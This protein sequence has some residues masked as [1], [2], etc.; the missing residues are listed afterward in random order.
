MLSPADQEESA[1]EQRAIVLALDGESEKTRAPGCRC[2]CRQA[3]AAA[4]GRLP[5]PLV[6]LPAGCCR[7]LLLPWLPLPHTPAW[8]ALLLDMHS[9]APSRLALLLAIVQLAAQ[10]Q[11]K[12]PAPQP[13]LLSLP[14]PACL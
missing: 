8:P 14:G 10:C 1:A 4:A 7:L 3:A 2:R 11:C 6:P 13:T 9:G 5:P 12:P